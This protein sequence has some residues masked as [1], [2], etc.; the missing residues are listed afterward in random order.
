M[1]RSS[2]HPHWQS[3]DLDLLEN[4]DTLAG[5]ANTNRVS[6]HQILAWKEDLLQDF[7]HARRSSAA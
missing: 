1:K 6:I 3:I 2:L 5:L 7:R 4:K